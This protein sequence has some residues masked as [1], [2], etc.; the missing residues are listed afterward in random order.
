MKTQSRFIKF[1]PERQLVFGIVYEPLKADS[2]GDWAT[3][4]V[5][6]EIAHE[7]NASNKAA[8]I[9]VA[10]NLQPCGARVVESFISRKGDPDYPPGAWVMGIKCPPPIWEL[11]KAKKINGLSMYGTG[12]RVP[13]T[14]PDQPHAKRQIVSAQI[15]AVSLVERAANKRVFTMMKSNDVANAL[16]V[17][18]AAMERTSE[19]LERISARIDEQDERFANLETGNVTKASKKRISPKLERLLRKREKLQSRLE[20]GWESPGFSDEDEAELLKAIEKNADKIYALGHEPE[21]A[22]LKTNSA[23]YH[24]GGVSTF[25]T[26]GGESL[27]DVLGVSRHTRQIEKDADE[28][29]LN[30]L[31][32]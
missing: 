3:D 26:G 14:L 28:I 18:A 16:E 31:V 4:E 5:I 21:S 30:C 19:T 13:R 11:I 10:H 32:I 17:I 20:T 8:N 9:D 24:R 22:T 6:E 1:D 29:S 12:E 27:D 15:E 7:F 25:I 23:F 2:Q